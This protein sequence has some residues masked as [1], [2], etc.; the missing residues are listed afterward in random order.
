MINITDFYDF[1][2]NMFTFKAKTK[3]SR[4]VL[5]QNQRN[6]YQTLGFN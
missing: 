4:N 6:Y 1:N 5:K 2:L 3:D